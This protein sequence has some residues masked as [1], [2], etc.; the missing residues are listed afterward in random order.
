M[1]DITALAWCPDGSCLAT[2]TLSGSLFLWDHDGAPGGHG[3]LLVRAQ[4]ELCKMDMRQAW[5]CCQ[6]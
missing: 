6:A 1:G 5:R 2:G 4:R 3:A